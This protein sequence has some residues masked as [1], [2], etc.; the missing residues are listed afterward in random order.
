M[1]FWSVRGRLCVQLG[2]RRANR[3]SANQDFS[4]F[5]PGK[6]TV[7]A[8]PLPLC[9]PLQV[10]SMDFIAMKRSQLYGLANNPY[11]S[12]QQPGGGPYPPSQP[13]T[14]PPQHRYPMSMQGRSPMTMGGMQYPQ[15]QVRQPMQE[16]LHEQHGSMGA[17]VTCSM[18]RRSSCSC[19]GCLPTPQ[20]ILER[21]FI[22]VRHCVL[23]PHLGIGSR[24][25]CSLLCARRGCTRDDL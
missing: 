5:E 2:R 22:P 16:P 9:S 23:I 11:S 12:P 18:P 1:W 14:S 24:H 3:L 21:P 15:Q 13:Y 8:L 10:S 6:K 25:T 4:A 19:C 20:W 17:R 7:T